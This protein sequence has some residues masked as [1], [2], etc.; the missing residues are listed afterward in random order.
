MGGTV[1]YC[2]R[3][4]M[5]SSCGSEGMVRV[6]WLGYQ[7]CSCV[8]R[9][10]DASTNCLTIMPLWVIDNWKLCSC[11]FLA[12]S[13]NQPCSFEWMSEKKLGY[14]LKCHI[15]DNVPWIRLE[16][17]T[18]ALRSSPSLSLLGHLWLP[19]SQCS[20]SCE[21]S[22]KWVTSVPTRQW[23]LNHR[24]VNVKENHSRPTCLIALLADP[25][26]LLVA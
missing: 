14:L 22:L 13:Y 25:L 4:N 24:C 26:A 3:R 10:K 2:L 19:A 8:C 5:K 21:P 18:Y 17:Y 9:G 15:H 16:H 23:L 11:F 7:V 12:I 6:S 20:V 1:V